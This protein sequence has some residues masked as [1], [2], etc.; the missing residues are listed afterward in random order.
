MNLNRYNSLDKGDERK[1]EGNGGG[2]FKMDEELYEE[3]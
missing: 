2:Y 3:N 1:N